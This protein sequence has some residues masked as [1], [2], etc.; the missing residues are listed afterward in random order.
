M[1]KRHSREARA[2]VPK[3]EHIAE[4]DGAKMRSI[5]V[6]YLDA[7]LAGDGATSHDFFGNQLPNPLNSISRRGLKV[8]QFAP[9]RIEDRSIVENMKIEPRH[10]V[11]LSSRPM[12]L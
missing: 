11:L 12:L 4:E 2:S 3:A 8:G 5:L 9:L 6:L 1:V 10:L 7:M